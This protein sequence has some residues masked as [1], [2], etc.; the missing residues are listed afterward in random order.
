MDLAASAGAHATRISLLWAGWSSWRMKNGAIPRYVTDDYA[1]AGSGPTRLSGARDSE[2]PRASRRCM[3]MGIA[4][5]TR[6]SFLPDA[7]RV[8]VWGRRFECEYLI[9]FR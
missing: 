5:T 4:L 8:T 1:T 9:L 2:L 3:C 6:C 7:G